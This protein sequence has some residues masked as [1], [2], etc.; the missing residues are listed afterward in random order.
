[1]AQQKEAITLQ[2]CSPSLPHL[3]SHLP[4]AALQ[5][6]S[7]PFQVSILQS[8][9]RGNILFTC[10]AAALMVTKY[11]ASWEMAMAQI[12]SSESVSKMVHTGT[13]QSRD[14][15]GA[16]GSTGASRH[17]LGKVC[18]TT[19]GC[20][21][22]GVEGGC[23]HWCCHRL[24]LSV[25]SIPSSQVNGTGKQLTRDLCRSHSMEM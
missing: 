11:L 5:K 7:C 25:P 2:T 13:L 15:L 23:K 4:Y 24:V 21:E 3:N 10:T 14:R 9:E 1:M 22:E 19:L 6:R 17:S 20:V 18:D 12:P 8:Y 16:P